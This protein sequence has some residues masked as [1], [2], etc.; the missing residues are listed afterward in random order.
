M[1]GGTI[2]NDDFD[3]T[4]ETEAQPSSAAMQP[5]SAQPADDTA[6]ATA[7][8]STTQAATT[9]SASADAEMEIATESATEPTASAAQAEVPSA[10]A[11]ET[12]SASAS[13]KV[14]AVSAS[15]MSDGD[16]DDEHSD[17]D[18]ET[19]DAGGPTMDVEGFRQP[20]AQ[21]RRQRRSNKRSAVNVSDANGRPKKTK[22]HQ[23]VSDCDKPD[24]MDPTRRR[25]SWS[26]IPTGRR[27]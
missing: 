23:S 15:D 18:G 25:Q 24:E 7:S 13:A 19:S 22:G 3:E 17:G 20:T 6:T 16:G 10:T 4:D 11:A 1:R 8:E 27:K 2:N 26:K 14:I 9:A 5:S 12:A 21:A